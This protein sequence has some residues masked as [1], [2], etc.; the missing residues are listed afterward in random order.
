MSACRIQKRTTHKTLGIFDA[1]I[2]RANQPNIH[3]CDVNADIITFVVNI[4]SKRHMVN[5]RNCI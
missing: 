1:K 5:N 4:K 2:V 3:M